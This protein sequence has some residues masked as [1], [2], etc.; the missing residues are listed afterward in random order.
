MH[1]KAPDA[2]FQWSIPNICC[3]PVQLPDPGVRSRFS[4]NEKIEI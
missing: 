4:I 2:Q 1:H 3:S